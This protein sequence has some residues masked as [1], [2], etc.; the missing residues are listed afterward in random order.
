MQTAI[1]AMVMLD[2]VNCLMVHALGEDQKG[3][4]DGKDCSERAIQ[5]LPS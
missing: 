5:S 4:C 3:Y 1:F 2:I